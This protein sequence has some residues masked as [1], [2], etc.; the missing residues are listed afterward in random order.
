MREETKRRIREVWESQPGL[1]HITERLP[2]M[3]C[4]LNVV[5]AADYDLWQET[6]YDIA[7]AN[8]AFLPEDGVTPLERRECMLAMLTAG[9]FDGLSDRDA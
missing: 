6:P 7:D 4:A 1:V 2:G 9:A 5:Y 3:S 8:D